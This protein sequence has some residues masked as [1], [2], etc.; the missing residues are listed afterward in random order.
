MLTNFHLNN[1]NKTKQKK[2]FTAQMFPSLK[3]NTETLP[4]TL[5]NG[6]RHTTHNWT[7]QHNSFKTC[8]LVGGR[9][10]NVECRSVDPERSPKVLKKK[11]THTHTTHD[12][13]ND[14]SVR[15]FRLGGCFLLFFE[16]C[17]QNTR[18]NNWKICWW[19]WWLWC[20][21]DDKNSSSCVLAGHWLSCVRKGTPP[22]EKSAGCVQS[23]SSSRE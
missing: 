1:K 16:K 13:R 15:W 18:K 10:R 17:F 21:W 4:D 14:G 9:C 20:W 8:L 12:R 6:K 5:P 7:M 3:D 22:P 11:H 23:S 19:G 2:R